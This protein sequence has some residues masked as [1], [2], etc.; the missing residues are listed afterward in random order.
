MTTRWSRPKDRFEMSEGERKE[1]ATRNFMTIA[2]KCP[3]VLAILKQETSSSHHQDFTPVL[4]FVT[5]MGE[6]GYCPLEYKKI[7]DCSPNYRDIKKRE[8]TAEKDKKECIMAIY[9]CME[10][11]FPSTQKIGKNIN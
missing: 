7:K 6:Q 8:A 9:S 3:Q 11:T 4:D 5:C 10:H 1:V 2:Q